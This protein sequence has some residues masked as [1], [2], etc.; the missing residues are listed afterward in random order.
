MSSQE[1]M[2]PKAEMLPDENSYNDKD[3]LN[4][5]LISIKHL[6]GIYSLACQEASN[7]TL[8]GDL[9]KLSAEASQLQRKTYDLMFE[10][11]WYKLEKEKAEKIDQKN[12]TFSSMQ[13][14]L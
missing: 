6:A 4:D 2:N 13:S 1:V 7:M 8:Y 12:K 14:Q 3:R 10:K 5:L 11:G 9:T